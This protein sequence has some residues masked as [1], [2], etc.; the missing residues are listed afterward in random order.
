MYT[1]E[2]VDQLIRVAITDVMEQAVV[3]AAV[4]LGEDAETV[5]AFFAAEI[6]SPLEKIKA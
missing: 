1:D 3:I 2:Q 4:L 5:G 6:Q